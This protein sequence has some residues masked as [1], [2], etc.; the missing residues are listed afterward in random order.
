MFEAINPIFSIAIL[1]M[2]V[3]AHEVSHGYV[4]YMLGDPTAKLA[5]RL[6]LNPI[7]HIDPVG[8]I[9]VPLL[10]S[11]AGFTFGWAKP[12]P[13]NPYNLRGGDKAAASVALAGP[14]MNL[15]IA[16]IFGA[17]IKMRVFDVMDNPDIYSLLIYI[18]LIN[19]VLALFNLTPIPPFDGSKVLFSIL[20][21]NQ[22]KVEQFLEANQL[23]ILFFFIF[24]VWG[25]VIDPIVSL[26]LR[27]LVS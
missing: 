8:S 4:A 23:I 15:F 25:I 10:T 24:F 26:L 21:Y 11:L 16:F 20:P 2:S 19:F 9:V 13:Y 5:G 7:K 22:R 18:V 3:V 14:V 12:V 6:T 17:M 27:Y 1:I